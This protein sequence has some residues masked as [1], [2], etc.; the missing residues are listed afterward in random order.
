MQTILMRLQ[1]ALDKVLAALATK[2]P[3]FVLALVVLGIFLLLAVG[4]PKQNLA[5]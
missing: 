5:T 4:V 3:D 1:T 2:S